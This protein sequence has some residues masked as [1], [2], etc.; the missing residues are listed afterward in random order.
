M[1]LY[2]EISTLTWVQHLHVQMGS[3]SWF[4][5]WNLLSCHSAGQLTWWGSIL[6]TVFFIFSIFQVAFHFLFH[7]FCSILQG[8]SQLISSCEE[9][10]TFHRSAGIN[11]SPC[12]P[13]KGVQIKNQVLRS[14]C[15]FLVSCCS[16]NLCCSMWSE[17]L[18]PPT[19]VKCDAP[20]CYLWSPMIISIY[21]TTAVQILYVI[22][23]FIPILF[24]LKHQ[25]CPLCLFSVGL[26]TP[27][28]PL[29]SQSIKLSYKHKY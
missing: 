17:V 18:C 7:V 20:V 11:S 2:D 14:W 15:S 25:Q 12:D 24:L 4:S 8:Y 13:C 26:L 27:W 9:L 22:N 3:E 16:N 29:T 21:N 19:K 6:Y 1:K 5:A 28:L 10:D 23:A